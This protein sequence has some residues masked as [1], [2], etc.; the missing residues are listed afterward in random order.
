MLQINAFFLLIAKSAKFEPNR[1]LESYGDFDDD[2]VKLP[3]RGL[4]NGHANASKLSQLI[5]TNPNKPKV[6]NNILYL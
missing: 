3:T 5:T 4:T 2:A 1:K 6:Q